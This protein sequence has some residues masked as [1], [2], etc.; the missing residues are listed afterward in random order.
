MANSIEGVGVSLMSCLLGFVCDASISPCYEA[1]V[2]FS[3]TSGKPSVAVKVLDKTDLWPASARQFL[4][5]CFI[6][7]AV[8]LIFSVFTVLD[9]DPH[10][11]EFHLC[12][13]LVL[14]QFIFSEACQ[15]IPLPNASE[16]GRF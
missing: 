15:A 1:F 9:C 16:H 11:K 4:S 8:S 6:F 10:F 3:G 14:S 2:N 7:C 12:L 5:A 13:D